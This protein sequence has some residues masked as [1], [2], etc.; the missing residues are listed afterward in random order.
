[1]I[2]TTSKSVPQ[3]LTTA[4]FVSIVGRPLEKQTAFSGT[5]N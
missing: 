3:A 1:M 4:M 5:D 2:G